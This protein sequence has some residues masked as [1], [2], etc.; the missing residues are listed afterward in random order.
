ME[1]KK[2][3]FVVL[4]EKDGKESVVDEQETFE[5]AVKAAENIIFTQGVK[6]LRVAQVIVNMS[7]D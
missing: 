4:V 3:S 5:L 7:V 6:K 1:A 2:V